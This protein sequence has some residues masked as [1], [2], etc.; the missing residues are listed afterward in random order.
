MEWAKCVVPL[1]NSGKVKALGRFM[2]TPKFLSMMQEIILSVRYSSYPFVT[3]CIPWTWTK[4][5]VLP[6]VE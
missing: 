2:G 1:V 5:L 6:L 4:K 3:A